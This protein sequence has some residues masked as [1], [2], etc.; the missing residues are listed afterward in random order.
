MHSV[1]KGVKMKPSVYYAT[2]IR[3]THGHSAPV[4]YMSSNCKKAKK[5]LQVLQI[6][7]PEIEWVAVAPY[8]IVVQRLLAY[9]MVDISNVLTVD[10]EIGDECDGLLCHLWEK[11]EGAISEYQRQKTEF[12]KVCCLLEEEGVPELWKSQNWG[13]LDAF[14]E[15][16]LNSYSK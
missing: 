16:V 3:G 9:S 13:V 5:N 15:S 8:D 14:V 2:P 12:D 7:Y 4:G 6:V 11:S 1:K 10:F